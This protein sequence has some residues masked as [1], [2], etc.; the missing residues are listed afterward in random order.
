MALA[1]K[2]LANEF[3]R[4]GFPII[5]HNTY[6]FLVTAVSWRGLVTRFVLL[7]VCGVSRS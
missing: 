3:N 2:L 1:E 5:D 6:V 4:P 7:Q